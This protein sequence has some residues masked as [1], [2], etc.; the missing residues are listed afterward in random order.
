MAWFRASAVSWLITPRSARYIRNCH[1]PEQLC[2]LDVN[3]TASLRLQTRLEL[4]PDKNDRG[5]NS[6][7]LRYCRYMAGHKEY[8]LLGNLQTRLGAG[9]L[10]LLHQ[11]KC[12]VVLHHFKLECALLRY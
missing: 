10:A 11:I 5:D 12:L 3:R 1:I 6:F 9:I 8:K 4:V 7:V 2:R